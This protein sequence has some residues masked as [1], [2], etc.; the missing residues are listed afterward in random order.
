[1]VLGEYRQFHDAFDPA[2]P[3]QEWLWR[4]TKMDDRD[5]AAVLHRFLFTRNDL[6]R[7]IGT[8]SGGEKSR[9]QLAR[10]VTSKISFLILD[11]PTNHLDIPSCEQLEEM[12]EEFDGTL[13]VVSHD[14]YFLDRLVTRV[15]EVED[16]GLVSHPMGFT[17]WW[18]AK[19]D[20]GRR[21]RRR[22]LVEH[23]PLGSAPIQGGG[24]ASL[25]ATKEREREQRKRRSRLQAVE[26]DIAQLE[27]RQSEALRALE[28]AATGSYERE[29][30]QRLE[31]DYAD[32]CARLAALY[33]EWEALAAAW[34]G[35]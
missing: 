8:L 15:I 27:A 28:A 5:T 26:K 23:G 3:V 11:E 2:L 18:R 14:R 33:A 9:L 31:S 4:E 13:L 25:A 20:A 30:M 10:L 34:E 32:A 35:A 24:G 1:M 29:R 7:P 6:A 22:A 21:R 12:L 19:R 17:E 16:R